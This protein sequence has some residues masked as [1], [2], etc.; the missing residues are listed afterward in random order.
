MGQRSFSCRGPSWST[1]FPITLM[2]R[3]SVSRPTGTEI[4][5][6]RSSASMPLTIPSVGSM[7]TQRT[8]FS[9]GCCSTSAVTSIA[10]EDSLERPWI[11]TALRMDGRCSSGNSMSMTG[12][13]IRTTLP[14]F[15]RS[16]SAGPRGSFQRR[17][18]ADNLQDLLG[19]PGLA[20]LVHV[21]GQALDHLGGVLG[22][23]VH[24]R[25]PGSLLGGGRLQKRPEDLGLHV[26]R[27]DLVE[28]PFSP[29]S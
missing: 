17:G 8:R 28:K 22:G 6:P 10:S 18:A 3:P 25:H 24:R 15:I 13:I 11:R 1:G 29:G 2:T 12:P 9:P 14:L 20:D 16:F 7:A 19:D 23:R 26:L 4:G 27:E 21:E 5:S